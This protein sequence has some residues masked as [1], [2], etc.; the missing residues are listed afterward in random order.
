MPPQD[1]DVGYLQ[2]PGIASTQG[3]REYMEDRFVI[4]KIPGGT[5]YAVFDGHGGS[6]VADYACAAVVR[7]PA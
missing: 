3:G 2:E 7:V 5:L 6:V 1:R 4:G